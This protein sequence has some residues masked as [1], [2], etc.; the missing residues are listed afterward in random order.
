MREMRGTTMVKT[1][2]MAETHF[3]QLMSHAG[4]REY[5]QIA[6]RTQVSI[7]I[8]KLTLHAGGWGG[9]GGYRAYQGWGGWQDWCGCFIYIVMWLNT[10]GIGCMTLWGFGA[11]CLSRWVM[12][13]LK[14]QKYSI[15]MASIL[16][17][18]A[19]FP[20]DSDCLPNVC[21]LIWNGSYNLSKLR[22]SEL[23]GGFYWQKCTSW[24]KGKHNLG[25]VSQTPI[26]P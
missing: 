23:G 12:G 16:I 26:P 4:V 5:F 14:V 25:I 7:S 8:F 13:T 19:H 22:K 24:K 2:L 20:K 9:R 11:K 18:S 1:G 3:R 10:I 21:Y 15:S 17:N 6:C